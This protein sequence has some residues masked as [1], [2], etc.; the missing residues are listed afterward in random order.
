MIPKDLIC[1][2]CKHFDPLKAGCDAFKEIPPSITSGHNDH[3]K[4]LAGQK[5]KITFEPI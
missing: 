2:K 3:S 5:N 4:P 1:E